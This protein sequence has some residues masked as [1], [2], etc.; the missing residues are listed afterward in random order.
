[1]RVREPRTPE[2]RDVPLASFRR[3][4]PPLSA[5]CV[6]NL[7]RG[8]IDGRTAH[9]LYRSERSKEESYSGG[10]PDRSNDADGRRPALLP[11]GASPQSQRPQSR[12]DSEDD[13]DAS[14]YANTP[15]AAADVNVEEVSA[16]DVVQEV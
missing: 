14:E 9:K 15:A 2:G 5:V 4:E 1:M 3:D 8:V 7:R 6:D 13:E 12:A 10:G 16:V 11:A